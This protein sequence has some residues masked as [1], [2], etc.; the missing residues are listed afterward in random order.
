MWY[1]GYE[2]RQGAFSGKWYVF[3]EHGE[4]HLICFSKI[5][6]MREV[7]ELVCHHVAKFDNA[8]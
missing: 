5:E 1:K 8:N 3:D 4:G 2:I 6:A 7:D